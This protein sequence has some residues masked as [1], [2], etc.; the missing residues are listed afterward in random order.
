M[1]C[2]AANRAPLAV[3]AKPSA[4]PSCTFAGP[5]VFDIKDTAS[6]ILISH[7]ECTECLD[8]WVDSG[9]VYIPTYLA[10]EIIKKYRQKS[11]AL[12][13]NQ[14]LYLTGFKDI[15]HY[16]FLDSSNYGKKYSVTGKVVG[17]TGLGLIFSIEKYKELE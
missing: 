12:P 4:T 9:T 3:W 14:D 2:G 6:T 15:T 8:A 1:I 10:L 7:H 11:L 17:L 16:L 5:L 13:S